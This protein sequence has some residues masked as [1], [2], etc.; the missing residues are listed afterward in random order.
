[1][2]AGVNHRV[3]VATRRSTAVNHRVGFSILHCTDPGEN[4]PEHTPKVALAT[5]SASHRRDGERAFREECAL[6][7][8]TNGAHKDAHLERWLQLLDS[9][10]RPGG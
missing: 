8:F 1:M 2:R 9:N 5:S 3:T 7:L 6:V 10:Q 4:R